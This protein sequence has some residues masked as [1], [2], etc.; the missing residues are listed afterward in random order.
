[1]RIS[2]CN[3]L[4]DQAKK[5]K[6]IIKIDDVE[7]SGKVVTLPNIIDRGNDELSRGAADIVLSLDKELPGCV[8]GYCILTPEEMIDYI[9]FAL[10]DGGMDSCDYGSFSFSLCDSENFKSDIS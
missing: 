4:S 2:I 10:N 5:H 1:M 8:Y 6:I 7:Y 3:Y 9:L